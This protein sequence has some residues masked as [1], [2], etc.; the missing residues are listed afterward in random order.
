MQNFEQPPVPLRLPPAE[1]KQADGSWRA[2]DSG[3]NACKAFR[4]GFLAWALAN[5]RA[6]CAYC[7]LRVGRSA[8]RTETLDHF[9]PKGGSGAYARWTYEPLNLLVACHECNSKLKVAVV[10]LIEPAAPVYDA[11]QFTIFHPYL[12]R[13]ASLHFVGGYTGRAKPRIVKPQS[14]LAENTIRIFE[15]R[16]P[17]LLHT[18]MGEYQQDRRSARLARLRA[19]LRRLMLRARAEVN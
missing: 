19:P 3:A 13:P 17:G 2:W 8:R 7:G 6:R 10:A 18:W 5:Q 12:H 4:R 1:W 14:Q 9:I 16:D 15:L 11:C